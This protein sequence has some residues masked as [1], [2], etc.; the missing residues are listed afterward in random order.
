MKTGTHNHKGG[1]GNQRERREETG[2]HFS[3]GDGKFVIATTKNSME[4]A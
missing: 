3:S 1:E 4:V 2:P